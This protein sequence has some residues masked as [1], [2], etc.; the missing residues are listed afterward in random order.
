[1][2]S[3]D[4]TDRIE[5]GMTRAFRGTLVQEQQQ[6]SGTP[7]TY[8]G[9]VRLSHS[10]SDRPA[11]F[12]GI[13]DPGEQIQQKV[14]IFRGQVCAL[15]GQEACLEAV[16]TDALIKVGHPDCNISGVD[17]RVWRSDGR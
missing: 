11:L 15:F 13:I 10:S 9:T 4:F 7:A 3:D 1:M 17:A 2:S 14:L 8:A 5:Q 12:D 16:E 6:R